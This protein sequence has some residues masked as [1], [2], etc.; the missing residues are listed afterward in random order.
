[1]TCIELPNHIGRTTLILLITILTASSWASAFGGNRDDLFRALDDEINR[2]MTDLHIG[3]LAR[4]YHIEARLAMRSHVGAHAV[5]GSAE[6]TDST[7]GNLLSVRVRVGSP[8]FDNTNFFDVSLGF[9]GST[10]QE[11]VFTNRRVPLELDYA[12]LRRELWLAIDACYKQA[13]EV[14]AKKQASAENRTRTDTTW[15]YTLIGA[16]DLV[17]TTLKGL[18]IT[19]KYIQD[20]V[21]NVSN[22]FRSATNLLSSRVAMEFNT[23]EWLYANSEG[24]RAHRFH[25]FT[26][27]E[28]YAV[29]QDHD[30]MPL[31][32]SYAAYGLKPSDLPTADSLRSTAKVVISNIV[33][34]QLSETIEA[35]NGP[36]LFTGQAAAEIFAQQFA[37]N[38]TAQRAM[39]SEGGV[40]MSGGPAMAFQN[41]IGARVLPEFLSV[42]ATPLIT[43]YHGTPVAGYYTID[44]EGMPAQNVN[45]I[46]KGYLRS[47][48]SGRIPTR[49]IKSSNGHYRNGSPMISVLELTNTDKSKQLTPAAMVKKLMQLRKD[50]ELDYVLVVS[51]IQDKNLGATGVY[52]LMAGDMP[53]ASGQ[54]IVSP[55]QVY[56][57]YADGRTTPVRGVEIAGI[58]AASFK[59]ILA[60]GTVFNA[61]NYLAPA[62]GNAFLTG[63]SGYTIATVIVPD[64]LFEDVEIRPTEADLP[65]LPWVAPPKIN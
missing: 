8:R 63:G 13:L 60:T 16:D 42:T 43:R 48:L 18:T 20:L 4:P 12:T 23:E 55:L 5:L 24:R 45:L 25:A 53:M 2:A 40:S 54:N 34:L 7:N 6:D 62:I 22:V 38:L 29:A 36:V 58:S 17:D 28:M 1:M 27:F 11:E 35:Y 49:R 30:G 15:D 65:K 61:H 51:S 14:Y 33:N 32:D 37:P 50:R 19:Q 56:K 39:A 21:E 10:D 9:F 3:E 26:G 64:L 59:D 46:V 57:L 44:D 52:P 41:K 47:L 31:S